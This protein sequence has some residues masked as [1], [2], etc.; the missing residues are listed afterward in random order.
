M[1]NSKKKYSRRNH[2]KHLLSVTEGEPLSYTIL[3]ISLP[4][5]LNLPK[6][7][8]AI[9]TTLRRYRKQVIGFEYILVFETSPKGLDHAHLIV[10]KLDTSESKPVIQKLLRRDIDNIR[11]Q[12]FYWLAKLS[13]IPVRKKQSL[14]TILENI[15]GIEDPKRVFCYV[16]TYLDGE[17]NPRVAGKG[18]GFFHYLARKPEF[19]TVEASI[20]SGISRI[21][22]S[23]KKKPKKTR[24]PAGKRT[25]IKVL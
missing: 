25:K 21:Y 10:F 24:K 1:E 22:A 4:T 7:K 6:W 15:G 9:L 16:K 14:E 23:S 2:I 11:Y 5:S 8:K 18:I 20:S 13:E 12:F 17:G 19:V 3:G